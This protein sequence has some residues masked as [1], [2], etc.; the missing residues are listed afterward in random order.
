MGPRRAPLAFNDKEVRVDKLPQ[1][2]V[3]S[4]KVPFRLWS[5][6]FISVTT[7]Y[8]PFTN[9]EHSLLQVIP[10]QLPMQGFGF[11]AE[12]FHGTE[13]GVVIHV[14]WSPLVAS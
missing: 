1:Q 6:R 7:Q 5:S 14:Q 13:F 2:V 8:A 12:K 10:C 11:G 9:I 3:L 4:G